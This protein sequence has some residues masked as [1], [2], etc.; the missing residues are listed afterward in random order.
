[1][2]VAWRRP[3]HPQTTLVRS[4]KPPPPKTPST[5]SSSTSQPTTQPTQMTNIQTK[6]RRNSTLNT[7]RSTLCKLSV[8]MKNECQ[9]NEIAI[10][11]Q[12]IH[13]GHRRHSLAA[14]SGQSVGQDKRGTSRH[15]Y[16]RKQ[17]QK[18]RRRSKG[19]KHIIVCS[20]CAA[21]AIYSECCDHL[22]KL[23]DGRRDY[24][25]HR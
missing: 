4:R 8:R 25:K 14:R 3:K 22:T 9:L 15:H 23:T 7:K 11:A 13:R 12:V 16:R 24:T 17:L 18:R 10:C 19:I 5:T 21:H 20:L 6:K 1:M 2:K